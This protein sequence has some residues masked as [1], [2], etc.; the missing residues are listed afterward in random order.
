M[1]ERLPSPRGML[2]GSIAATVGGGFYPLATYLFSVLGHNPEDWAKLWL[3]NIFGTVSFGVFAFFSR[4]FY[5]RFHDRDGEISDLKNDLADRQKKLDVARSDLIASQL[6]C[7]TLEATLKERSPREALKKAK[8]EARENNA[9]SDYAVRQ[10]LEHQGE[11]VSEL[12]FSRAEWAAA[13]AAGDQ[14]AAGLVAAEAYSIAAIALW[15]GNRG[16]ADLLDDIRIIKAEEAH[17]TLPLTQSLSELQNRATELFEPALVEAADEAEHEAR[18]RFA[19]GRY[20]A[21]L[22]AVERAIALRLWTVGETG[23]KTSIAKYIKAQILQALGHS[24]EALRI[25]QEVA[26]GQKNALGPSHQ[27]TLES[28]CLVAGLLSQLRYEK[29]ALPIAQEVAEAQ[30]NALGPSH[31]T[32]LARRRFVASLLFKLGSDEAALRIAEEVAEAQEKNRSLGRTHPNTLASRH[33]VAAILS[34]LGRD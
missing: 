3:G 24:D 27:D 4:Y 10:W 30:K 5:V 25:A 20:H 33:L 2:E 8:D 23:A 34:K 19:R 7:K 28:R 14:R 17:P 15:P 13:Y 16:A 26:E 22:P 29:E 6:E 21:A 32:T 9:N 31:P 12:L 1:V 18:R 11:D